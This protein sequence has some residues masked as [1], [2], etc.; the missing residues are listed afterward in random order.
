MN[1][2]AGTDHRPDSGVVVCIGDLVEDVVVHLRETIRYATDTASQIVRHRGGSAANTAAAI[3]A[4]GGRARFIGRVG[5]DAVGRWATEQ[6]TSLGVEVM[7]QRSGRTGTIVALVD[8]SGE[9]SMLT[10]RGSSPD[11]TGPEPSWFD[12]AVAVHVPAYGLF[13]GAIEV[14]TRAALREARRRGLR[15][16]VDVSATRLIASVGVEQMTDV[17]ADLRPDVVLCNE[18]EAAALGGADELS[19]R[20]AAAGAPSV[21]V[22]AKHGAGDAEVVRSGGAVTR[23]PAVVLDGPVD[24]TGAGDAF[25]AGLLMALAAG[26]DDIAAVRTAHRVAATVIS[27]GRDQSFDSISTATG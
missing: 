8:P 13:G 24:T 16:S 2:N 1:T 18:D 25:T 17:L 26:D 21:L 4:A 7:V 10:D 5:D 12:G 14:T 19:A 6:L 20:L 27:Q 11:L 9:R 3:A 15:T 23:V 22:V